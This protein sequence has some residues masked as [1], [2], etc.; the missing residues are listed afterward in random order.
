MT[1]QPKTQFP[2]KYIM[3]NVW[4]KDIKK[5]QTHFNKVGDYNLTWYVYEYTQIPTYMHVWKSC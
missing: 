3:F 1:N 2:K 4:T 5:P